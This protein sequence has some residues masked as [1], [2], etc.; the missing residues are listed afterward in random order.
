MAEGLKWR[1]NNAVKCSALPP[2]SRLIM[3]VLSDRADVRTAMIPA[4]HSPSV[5]DLAAETGLGDATVKRHLASLE[6]FG[7]IARERPTAEQMARHVSGTYRLMIGK[8]APD[9]PAGAQSDTPNETAGGSQGTPAGAQSD[10]PEEG[11]GAQ[12]DPT[13]GSERSLP[14]AQSDT[15]SQL[16]DRNDQ[17]YQELAADAA[18]AAGPDALFDAPKA[19][20][21]N[22]PR[23]SAKTKPT[24]PEAEARRKIAED[25]TR[26][27]W[28][29]LSKKP[30]GKYAFPARRDIVLALLE[31]GHE[32]DDV[33]EAAKRSGISLTS[34]G[35]EYQL[36]R[37]A[38]EAERARNV[39][40]FPRNGRGYTPYANPTD[41]SVYLQGIS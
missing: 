30:V 41:Q 25:L 3:F 5:G 26:Q 28:D 38:E 32:P 24:D 17:N 34:G 35:M 31:A 22:K 4:G 19:T 9:D 15:P 10:T 39:V 37:L 40:P 6:A 21:P 29:R 36:Q 8:G 18:E 1:V 7:W 11:S 2:P 12:S 16:N 23:A 20:R 33:A 13:G 27:W 14:G